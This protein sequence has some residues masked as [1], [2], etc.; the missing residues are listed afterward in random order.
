MAPHY[1]WL[2]GNCTGGSASAEILS[3]Q[4]MILQA[5]VVLRKLSKIAPSTSA[6][7]QFSRCIADLPGCMYVLRNG[8]R[9]AHVKK[10]LAVGYLHKA[11]LI[12]MTYKQVSI[13]FLK[14]VLFCIWQ[15][16]LQFLSCKTSANFRKTSANWR[17]RTQIKKTSVWVYGLEHFLESRTFFAYIGSRFNFEMVLKRSLTTFM[18][19]VPGLQRSM[20]TPEPDDDNDIDEMI[21]AFRQQVFTSSHSQL[22]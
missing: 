11:S 6:L 15:N 16:F 21:E 17:K 1:D 8:G 13:R 9:D 18:A 7:C 12:S 4:T 3:T 5:V 10:I 2:P 22:W 14:F 20:T 19:G